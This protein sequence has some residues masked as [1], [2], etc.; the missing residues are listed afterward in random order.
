MARSFV[1]L[2]LIACSTAAVGQEGATCPWL[3]S[4]TAAKLLGSDVTVAAQVEGSWAGSCRFMRQRG[5]SAAAIVSLVGPAVAQPCA[6]G[7]TKLKA[8]GNE[9]V[10]CQRTAPAAQPSDI[11]AGRIR[12]VYFVVTM[13]NVAT[14]TRREPADPRLADAYGASAL[15]RAAEQVVGN[16]Y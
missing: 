7:S 13:T 16:L 11:I 4:G 8:L 12:N 10:Q 14:A 1:L 6:Q 2:F 5:D 3:T 9:A 15:E